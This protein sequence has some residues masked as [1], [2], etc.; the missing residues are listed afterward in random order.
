MGNGQSLLPLSVAGGIFPDLKTPSA[1]P[2][3]APFSGGEHP[4]PK[5]QKT[6]ALHDAG[7]WIGRAPPVR[8][9]QTP[10][11]GP[12][13]SSGVEI[14]DECRFSIPSISPRRAEWM[15]RGTE[16]G[17]VPPSRQR[18]GVR[19]SLPL[20]VEGGIFP[21]LKTP[22]ALPWPASFSGGEHPPQKRRRAAALHDAAA[23]VGPPPAPSCAARRDESRASVFHPFHGP[24][25]NGWNGKMGVMG[26]DVG[27]R[28]DPTPPKVSRASLPDDGDR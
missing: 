13:F 22:S 21:D 1:L 19:Q 11:D 17:E 20:S 23:T 25:G 14:R 26:C 24:R 18:H 10:H 2:W 9:G 8:G 28:V 16:P 15:E 12:P 3:P 5:R 4:P 7:A 6:A 27:R